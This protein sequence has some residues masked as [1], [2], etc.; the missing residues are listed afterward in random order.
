[1]HTSQW[2]T[3]LLIWNNNFSTISTNYNW[4]IIICF[5]SK[6]FSLDPI[7]SFFFP[8]VLFNIIAKQFFLFFL[9]IH[10]NLLRNRS[11][12]D[13]TCFSLKCWWGTFILPY[14]VRWSVTSGFYNTLFWHTTFVQPCGTTSP[15]WMICKMPLKSLK[16]LFPL[17]YYNTIRPLVA[18]SKPANKCVV[19][20]FFRHVR[21]VLFIKLNWAT[22]Y[23][24]YILICPDNFPFHF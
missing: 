16:F 21:Q 11:L 20:D 7:S 2:Q 15:K 3:F 8:V 10:F 22:F 24:D 23:I 14:P 4:R 17:H 13:F 12:Q 19:T 5:S 6:T 1:M 18:W 9:D